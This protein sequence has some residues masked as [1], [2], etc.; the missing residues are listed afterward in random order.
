MIHVQALGD[1][2][3]KER[4]CALRKTLGIF[5]EESRMHFKKPQ[6]QR[7]IQWHKAKVF[8]LW[9]ISSRDPFL[10]QVTVTPL[11]DVRNDAK[12]V[13]WNLSDY[14]NF[15]SDITSAIVAFSDKQLKSF[16]ELYIEASIE[17][18]R[19]TKALRDAWYESVHQWETIETIN[20]FVTRKENN[21]IQFR[22]DGT[23]TRMWW[24]KGEICLNKRLLKISRG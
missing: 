10:L 16:Q 23:Y 19:F 9:D 2:S 12:I 15:F 6:I 22:D 4:K 8:S 14:T 13:L 1:L 5:P 21:D 24:Y 17:R 11:E 7:L 20:R 3:P 18:D